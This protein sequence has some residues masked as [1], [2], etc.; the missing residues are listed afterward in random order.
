MSMGWDTLV[1]IS[2]NNPT[3][4]AFEFKSFGLAGQGSHHDPSGMRGYRGHQ[5]ERVRESN[6]DVRGPGSLEPSPEEL[7]LLFPWILGANASGT[8]YALADTLQSRYV[9]VDRVAKVHTYAGVYINSATFRGVENQPLELSLD[10]IGQ[11]ETEGNAGSFPAITPLLTPPFMYADCVLTLASS[12]RKVKQFTLTINNALETQ[13]YNSQTA[14]RINPTDRMISLQCDVPYD[15]DN[16]AL[17]ESAVAGAAA[18]LVFTFGAYSLTF[19]FA[20]MQFPKIKPAINGRG[21]QMLSLSGMARRVSTTPEL[22]VTL[23]STP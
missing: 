15:T 20:T 9:Q 18:T 3:D 7:A 21:E 16:T 12:A 8:S 11:T 1:G 23:D 17:A 5:S 2:T 10:M 6:F 14:T 19:S 4:A 13:F 22:A